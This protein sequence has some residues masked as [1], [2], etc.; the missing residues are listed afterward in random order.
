MANLI[1]TV[2]IAGAAVYGV[3]QVSYTVD[4]AAGKDYGA[5]LTAAAFKESTAIEDTMNSYAA[6]VRPRMRKLEDLGTVMAGL[7][8]GMATLKTKDT[9]SSDKTDKMAVLAE[10]HTL[11]SK[12]GITVTCVA[13]EYSGG[14]LK[15]EEIFHSRVRHRMRSIRAVATPRSLSIVMVSEALL[16]G[17]SLAEPGKWARSKPVTVKV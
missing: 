9:E 4:G 12:Y 5:A 15:K 11:A 2:E 3:R 16:Q 1:D 10:A 8:A 7:N 14:V 13:Y 6:V 17:G